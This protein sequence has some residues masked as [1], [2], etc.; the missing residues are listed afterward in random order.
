MSIVSIAMLRSSSGLECKSSIQA[1]CWQYCTPCQEPQECV[2]WPEALRYGIAIDSYDTV[3][4]WCFDSASEVSH[5][6]R[7]K[8]SWWVLSPFQWFKSF[9]T[10]A[11]SMW[12]L[13]WS[14]WTNHVD[15][16]EW[17]IW[18]LVIF[19]LVKY[20]SYSRRII[21][22][23]VAPSN[24][25]PGVVLHYY[26]ESVKKFVAILIIMSYMY[27]ITKRTKLSSS[28]KGIRQHGHTD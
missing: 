22:L 1:Y 17:R 24:N 11:V 14:H 21:W 28:S 20:V 5:I 7:G 8:T 15:K 6:T 23:R 9:L 27:G 18:T 16:T 3:L 13:L 19:S 12:H 2:H 26:S 10:P 25:Q 4:G